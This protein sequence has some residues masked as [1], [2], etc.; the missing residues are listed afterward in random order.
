MKLTEMIKDRISGADGQIGIYF[1]DIEKN[2][3]FLS[4]TVMCFRL[5]A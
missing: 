4:E 1:C 2:T 5:W 3:S